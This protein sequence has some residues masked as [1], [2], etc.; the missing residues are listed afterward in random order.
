M[1]KT[2]GWCVFALTA[3][4]TPLPGVAHAQCVIVDQPEKR[5]AQAD[6]VFLGTVLRTE[7]TGVQ[8]AH[9]IV[10]IA[11]FRVE[12]TW[13]GDAVKEL[14]VGADRPFEKGREYLVFAGG[15]PL[16]TSI[17][18][19]WAEPTD[20][21]KPALDWLSK[22]QSPALSPAPAAIP[23]FGDFPVR[24]VF[25]GTP[26]VPILATPEARKF[27]TELTRQ[28]AQGPNFAGFY[29][30]ARWGC[31]AGCVT[32]AIIDART[33]QVWFP[34]FRVEDLIT[35]P[36][37]ITLHHG[38]GAELDSELVIAEGV[39]NEQGAGTAYF[40]WHDNALKLIRF[41]RLK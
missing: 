25:R 16:T 34:S 6:A 24:E 39:I 26:A 12:R 30:F 21:A 4:L 10:E 7:A 37:K 17:L 23:A 36:G 13:K 14:R 11:T 15:K 38:V 41:D 29:T 2:V 19:R 8:G 28:A 27:R 3:L 35:A 1:T 33:G 32:G 5:F 22:K 18:C 20:R 40:R 9:V 31:G